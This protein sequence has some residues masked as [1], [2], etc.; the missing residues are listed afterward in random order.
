[1]VS[2]LYDVVIIGASIAGCTAA[3]LFARQGLSVALVERQV[4]SAAYKKPCTH[5]IQ[6]SATPTI[7]RLGLDRMIEAAGGV[8][9][10]LEFHTRW[11]WVRP[12]EGYDDFPTYGYS[13]RRQKLDPLLRQLAANSSGVVFMPGY[14]AHE[15]VREN[16]RF[17]GV[18]VQNNR[19]RQRT[20]LQA[21]L[22]VAADGH[23]SRTA[24]LAGVPAKRWPNEHAGYFAYYAGT[25]LASGSRAQMW[26]CE[27]E[28]AYAFPNDEGLTLFTCILTREALPAF[29]QDVAN[30]FTRF[31]NCLPDSPDLDRGERVS[32]FLGVLKGDILARPA[33]VPGLA[34]IGDTALSSDPLWGVGCGWAFQSAAWLVDRVAPALQNG[35]SID[36]ALINYRR[37]HWRTLLSHHYHIASYARGRGFYPFEKLFFAAAAKDE[38][39]A[40]QMHA[41]AA[42][43]I[44][45]FQLA[46]P[47]VLARALY[48]K[49]SQRIPW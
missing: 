34:F 42:R 27:P 38:K 12:A 3:T 16:G 48:I 32:D 8:R 7:Q 24:E 46:S 45:F 23:Y 22:V 35:G 4:D 36:R 10:G 29:R 47:A 21:G 31:F 2:N 43:H 18:V 39:M 1:M 26:F 40:A 30:N 14:T 17:S 44:S 33:A 5:F 37:Y 19:L 28:V 49:V 9:N 11:G 15:L 20:R 6:A 25:P 13:L 41:Y